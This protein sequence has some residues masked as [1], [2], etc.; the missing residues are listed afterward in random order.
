MACRQARAKAGLQACPRIAAVQA[1]QP[2]VPHTRLATLDACAPCPA[3][4]L[5]LARRPQELGSSLGLQGNGPLVL[6][7]GVGPQA[8]RAVRGA[9]APLLAL[10]ARILGLQ[11][12]VWEVWGYIGQAQQRRR[13][14]W[15]G[16]QMRSRQH[17][18]AQEVRPIC[19]AC[20][21]LAPCL[22]KHGMA[23]SLPG[24]AAWLAQQQLHAPTHLVVGLGAA[25]VAAGAGA[26]GGK[27]GQDD[28][29]QIGPRV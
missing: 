3:M 1:H 6:A 14:C 22:P 26:V 21:H 8:A 29:P 28:G 9:V 5:T 25:E 27:R 16:K 2:S 4:P 13:A 18:S 19:L 15:A 10:G 20:L 23:A 24:W 7:G 12:Q 17:H 11:E